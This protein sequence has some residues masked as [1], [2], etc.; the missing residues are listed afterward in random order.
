MP[1]ERFWVFEKNIS[2][3]QASKNLE[4]L[5]IQAAAQGKD[6]YSD[7][8]ARYTHEVGVVSQQQPKLDRK[9]LSSLKELQ[10]GPLK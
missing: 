1:I 8:H 3:I 4:R 10:Q 7:L 5:N 6:S 2:R 9:G